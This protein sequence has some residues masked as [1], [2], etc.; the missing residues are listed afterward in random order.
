MAV[1]D[2]KEAISKGAAFHIR[3]DIAEFFTRIDKARVV[4]LVAPHIKCPDT[5]ALFQAAITTDLANN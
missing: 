5:L 4:E 3:S 2:A 1:T